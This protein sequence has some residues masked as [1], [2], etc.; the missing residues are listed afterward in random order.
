[1][2]LL[3]LPGTRVWLVTGYDAARAVLADSHSFANDV[4][5]LIGRQGRAPAER[6]GGLGMTDQPDHGRLRGVLTPYFTRRRLAELQDDID[7]VVDEALDDLAAHGPEVDLVSRFGFAVP[8]GVICD[9]LGLPDVD[10]EEFRRRGAARFDLRDGGSGILDTAAG[11]REFL[12]DLVASERRSPHLPDGLIA[13]LVAEHGGDFD[14]VEIGGLA[15]GVFLGG[16]E[17]SASMLSLGTYVLSRSPEAWAMLRHGVADEVDRVVEELLRYVCPVQIAF[18]RIA[19]HDVRVGSTTVCAGDIVSSPSPV[20]AATPHGTSTPRASTRPRQ[21]RA[22]SPSATACTAAWGRSWR[23]WS[24]APRSSGSPAGSPTCTSPVTRPT[25]VSPSW[26]SSTAWRSCRCGWGP[27]SESPAS[28]CHTRSV[29][30]RDARP[31]PARP[32]RDGGRG[33]RGL[34]EPVV[35]P[36]DAGPRRA[37][38]G[39]PTVPS[40]TPTSTPSTPSAEPTTEPTTEPERHEPRRSFVSIPELGMREFP[41]VRYPGSPDDAPGTA[42]QNAGEM[43]SPRGPTGGV[44][45]GEV[46]NFIVT[47]HRLTGAAPCA[48]RP[49]S[50]AATASGCAAATWSSSTR[51]AGPAGRRSGSRGRWPRSARRS[52]V[53]PAG[54]PPG[55]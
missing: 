1:M 43:A 19:R 2:P 45:P 6:I 9:L 35:R 21:A 53:V 41:V 29:R 12:I 44:G 48:T 31:V 36:C 3:R 16:Y 30:W 38:Y 4:R 15:D 7:R 34:L 52:R 17:T 10:R 32:R 47:G 14:D 20:Q 49:R 18:P 33:H 5:H 22:P 23:A 55:R 54:R 42:L 37:A 28:R 27:M 51:C 24:C 39:V 11:T 8:F 25:C 46:G 26:P 13:R 50:A 40:S